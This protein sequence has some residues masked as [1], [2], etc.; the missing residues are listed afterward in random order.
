MESFQ[1]LG[2]DLALSE[3]EQRQRSFETDEPMNENSILHQNI[4]R[5]LSKQV[6]I[7]ELSP[8]RR[9]LIVYSSLLYT[10]ERQRQ[11][12]RTTKLYRIHQY[13]LKPQTKVVFT[14]DLFVATFVAITTLMGY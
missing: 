13:L 12:C 2:Q 11:L 9:H 1:Y 10:L 5:E 3:Y 4:S 7:G 14:S 6:G 8:F